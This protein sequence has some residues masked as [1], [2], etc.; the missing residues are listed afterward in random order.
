M[1]SNDFTLTQTSGSAGW[2]GSVSV[3]GFVD[4]FNTITIPN[5]ESWIIHGTMVDGLPPHLEARLTSGTPDAVSHANIVLRNLR[6]T[7]QK[8]PLDKYVA[9]RDG[10]G[11]MR[12]AR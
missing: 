8:T 11:G 6:F 10:H 2:A 3:V 5:D 1:F 12:Q 9:T 4:F 7:E